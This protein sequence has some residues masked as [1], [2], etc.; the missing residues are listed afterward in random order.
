M[1]E[2][3]E[4]LLKLHKEENKKNDLIILFILLAHLPL[5]LLF[6]IGYGTWLLVL[7]SSTILSIFSYIIFV[8]SRGEK[9]LRY[10]N[11]A[12][13]MLFS[14]VLIQAQLGRIEMHFHVF[15][16]LAFLI[17]YR[18]PFVIL[19][20]AITIALHHALFNIFQDFSLSIGSVPLIVFNYGHGWDIVVIHAFFVIFESGILIYL[21]ILQK[22][23]MEKSWTQAYTSRGLIIQNLNLKPKLKTVSDSTVSLVDSVIKKS[24]S[25]HTNSTMQLSSIENISQS[26]EDISES[27]K[28]IVRNTSNQFD[29]TNKISA[30]R[31]SILE[32]SS[33]GVEKIT[34]S[35]NKLIYAKEKANA[36]TVQLTKLSASMEE[37][38]LSYNDMLNVISG[39][40][41]IADRI[42]LLSLN[43]S[44]ESAR[45]GEFGRGFSVVAQEISKLADQTA[46]NLKTSDKL[47]KNVR[48]QIAI[49][50]VNVGDTSELFNSIK[51]EVTGLE[52]VF[53]EFQSSLTHQAETFESLSNELD[54]LKNESQDTTSSTKLLN[55]SISDMKNEVKEF[56]NRTRLFS[57]EASDLKK[58]SQNSEDS[59]KLL[60]SSVEELQ[61][62]SKSISENLI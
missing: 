26:I 59:I 43:A 5:T 33:S 57:E 8:L 3:N 15:S 54:N 46:S 48:N 45:A 41:E 11:G 58:I 52:E 31:D 28:S 18:D 6:S 2:L 19:S 10:L 32:L 62:D 17:I 42:N 55:A 53:K 34:Q 51:E 13:F 30:T 50:K 60:V 49:S 35:N 1:D 14:A 40:Y 44:I 12:I 22:K 36:G 21:A 25:I 16:A 24:D 37:I 56:I 9:V 23:L 7:V 4:R 47:I 61:F 29:S 39:I 20:A 38:Q 27:V